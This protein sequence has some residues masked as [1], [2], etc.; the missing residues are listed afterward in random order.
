[1]AQ[2]PTNATDPSGEILPWI[3]ACV[4]GAAFGAAMDIGTSVL[5]GRKTGIRG[6]ITAAATGC[7]TNL[8]FI[9]LGALLTR[10]AITAYALGRTPVFTLAKGVPAKLADPRLQHLTNRLTPEHLNA[11]LNNPSATRL[12]DAGAKTWGRINVVQDVEGVLLRIT[13]R[14]DAFEIISVGP[15]RSSSLINGIAKGRF[16]VMK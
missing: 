3:G 11:L 10:P 16:V 15:M 7:L 4:V 13:V 2:T 1:V 9:G 12:F 8:F 14:G 6:T 5:T